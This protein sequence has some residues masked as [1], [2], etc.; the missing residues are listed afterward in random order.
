MQEKD[1]IFSVELA[2]VL[3]FDRNDR[4]SSLSSLFQTWKIPIS[5]SEFKNNYIE[6]GYFRERIITS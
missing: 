2:L 4:H 1:K 5:N 6:S 3:N